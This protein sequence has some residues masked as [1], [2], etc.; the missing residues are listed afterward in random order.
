MPP[1][2]G[3]IN[4]VQVTAEVFG[5]KKC[6]HYNN[7]CENKFYF[8]INVAESD[9]SLHLNLIF[10]ILLHTNDQHTYIKW[11]PIQE[12]QSCN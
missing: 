12:N 8:K 4:L 3:R 6:V 5:P 11:V 2:S 9:N 10:Y 1:H 7:F